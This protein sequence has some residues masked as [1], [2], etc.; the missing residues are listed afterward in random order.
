MLLMRR[1]GISSYAS[2]VEA[3]EPG[4]S[5]AYHPARFCLMQ[6]QL[7]KAMQSSADHRSVG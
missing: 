4:R 7:S 2:H 6:L 1:A 3:D 5:L